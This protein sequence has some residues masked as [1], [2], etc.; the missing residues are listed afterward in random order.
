MGYLLALTWLIHPI[1]WKWNSAKFASKI[2]N[3]RPYRGRAKPHIPHPY[4][5]DVYTR[6]SSSG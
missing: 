4:A 6:C 1:A 3:I 2:L 5:Y